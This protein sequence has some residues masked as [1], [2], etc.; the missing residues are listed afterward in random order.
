ML[1]GGTL[2]LVIGLLIGEANRLNVAQFSAQSLAAFAYLT[3]FGSIIAFTA[4][5]WLLKAVPAT[6]VVTYTYVNP[7]IA[8]FLGWLILSEPVTGTTIVSVVVIIL[9]VILI[10]TAR[11]TNQPAGE[12][13]S[14]PVINEPAGQPALQPA[15]EPAIEQPTSHAALPSRAAAEA[16]ESDSVAF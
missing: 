2:L 16:P 3:L 4:Y 6:K 15:Y 11:P 1:A 12:P 10:T 14:E 5:I 13:T 8:V 9:A 7:V